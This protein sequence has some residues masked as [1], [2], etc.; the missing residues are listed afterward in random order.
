MSAPV[1]FAE[2]PSHLPL[3]TLPLLKQRFAFRLA[4]TSY[5]LPEAILPNIA[6]LGPH[7]DEIELV[8][9]ESQDLNNL[10]TPAEIR[11]LVGLA[12]DFDLT[13]NVH[14]P[15]D[16]FFGDP[17]P[18]L[19][20]AFCTTAINFYERTLALNPTAFILHLDSRKADGEVEA[21]RAAWRHRVHES[22][23]KLQS[24]GMDLG[25]VVVEN[26]EYPLERVAS[27]AETFGMDLCFDIGHLLRYGHDLRKQLDA[28]LSKS[29][30]VH[31][32]G[33]KDGQDHLVLDHIPQQEWNLIC[34]ALK[35]F[36]GGVSLEVFS[37][38]DLI[39]SLHRIQ[40]LVRGE[41]HS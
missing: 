23:D 40:E 4:T 31:L 26:L 17:D 35:E 37:V 38:D 3:P 5:I 16:L 19:Q 41:E 13:Y 12:E 22:L 30:M 14:L 8:L 11:E 27:F 25:R 34:R 32:H 9:F 2:S 39:P 21:D 7:F 18:T 28:F 33:V 15:G 1:G 24:K 10:P 36:R 6:F 20:Q 29:T